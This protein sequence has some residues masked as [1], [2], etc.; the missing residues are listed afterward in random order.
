MN[1]FSKIF[2]SAKAEKQVNRSNFRSRSLNIEPLE[3][4]ALLS[5]TPL[6]P[7]SPV[8]FICPPYEPL[9]VW[10]AEADV[11][12]AP[13][14]SLEETFLLHSN[15]DA[16]HVIYLDFNGHTT[17]GTE[18]NNSYNYSNPISTPAYSFE[19]DLS[20]FSNAEKERIQYIWQR[21]AED[22]APFNVDVTTEEPDISH[23]IKTSTTYD[24][25]GYWGIRVV[26]GGSSSWLRES[27]GGVAYL[28]SFNWNSN[29]PVF[30]FPNN[31]N[32]G[33]EK[34][35]AEAISHEVGHS[36]G[37][38]H[39]GQYGT[40]YYPG[41]N[42]WAPIMGVGYD[43]P[44]VQW[45]RGEYPGATNSEDDLAIITGELIN[46]S[47]SFYGGN[48]FS[49]REDDYGDTP[50]TAGFLEVNGVNFS[51]SGIIEQNTDV[52]Y[53]AFTLPQ[54]NYVQFSIKSGTRDANLNVLAKIYNSADSDTP[55]A[56]GDPL[57]SLDAF[58]STK[59]LAAGTY[60]LTIEG[61]SQPNVFT[62][63][64]SIGTYTI[65]GNFSPVDATGD[66][67]STIVTT[68]EDIVDPNDG[69]IS[70][71]EAIDYTVTHNVG[72]VVRFDASLKNGTILL[73]G[74][75][76]IKQD[77]TIDGGKNNITID[78]NQ[79]SRVM[80]IT[81]SK[82][83][84]TL[85]GLTITG[86]HTAA[87]GG[88]IYFSS[89]YGALI[90]SN[91]TILGNTAFSNNGTG[92][93]YG[94]GIYIAGS[95]GHSSIINTVISENTSSYS[96]GGI[97]FRDG[98]VLTIIDSTISKNTTHTYGGGIFNYAST[99]SP[100]NASAIVNIT[101]SVITENDAKLG[102]GITNFGL[103]TITNSSITE[104][105]ASFRDNGA[106]G[107]AIHNWMTLIIINSTIARNSVDISTNPDGSIACGG[108]NN[109][110]N[111]S[112]TLRNTIIAENTA[113]G[114]PSDIDWSSPVSTN[115]SG[116]QGYN[117]LTSFED[118]T[119]DFGTNYVYNSSKPLFVGKLEDGTYDYHLAVDSPAINAG[120]NA[121][122]PQEITT[123]IEGNTRI[124]G[125]VVDIGAYE[126]YERNTIIVTTESDTIADDGV[127]SLREAILWATPEN[128]IITFDQS[129]NGKTLVMTGGV[130]YIN[131]DIVI[132]GT[133][134][135]LF[136]IDGNG[137]QIFRIGGRTNAVISGLTLQN[138]SSSDGGAV[139]GAETSNITISE[140]TL[141]NNRA[142]RGGAI[143]T[144]GNLTLIDTDLI[145]NTANYGGGAIMNIPGYGD[146][147][148]DITGGHMIGNTASY[149]GG[150]I[151]SRGD[152][153]NI[154][155]NL[156]GVEISKNR[157]MHG[158][159]V[160]AG[161]ANVHLTVKECLITENTAQNH[162][163]GLDIWGPNGTLDI[164]NSVITGNTAARG[165]GI[166]AELGNNSTAV[167][168]NS[169]IAK[170]TSNEGSGIAFF[171]NEN[172]QLILNNTTVA[173]NTGSYGIFS[174]Y[175]MIVLKNSLVANQ[176]AADV[177]GQVDAA[178]SLIANGE[179][180]SFVQNDHNIIGTPEYPIDPLFANREAGFYLLLPNSPA[181]NTGNNA[182]I[183][184]G[185]TTDLNGNA[186]IVGNAV[187]I[188]AYESSDVP[189][190]ETPS[191]IVTTENDIVNPYDHEISL[192]EAIQYANATNFTVTF[193]AS[194]SGKTIKLSHGEIVLNKNLTINGS[195]G[196][197]IIDADQKSRVLI[198]R[199][200]ANVTLVGLTIT[201]GKAEEYQSQIESSP[202][203]GGIFNQ[204]TLTVIDSKIIENTAQVGGGG[205]F[206][207]NGILT[208]I[209]SLIA[210]N[211]ALLGSG[212]LNDVG[213]NKTTITNS[214]IT[215]NTATQGSGGGIYTTDILNINNTIITGNTA[216]TNLDIRGPAR[217]NQNLS[218]YI[219][220]IDSGNTNLV[221]DPSQQL[222][223]DAANGD[224]HLAESSQAV[225]SGSNTLITPG[226]TK[227]IEGNDRIQGG[228]VDIGAYES[229]YAIQ[230]IVVTTELDVVDL[231][232]GLTSL[233][234]AINEAIGGR[235]F[236]TF[237]ES[238]AG[239][240]IHLLDGEIVIDKT[241][242]IDAGHLNITI[243]ADQKSRVLVV[244]QNTNVTLVGLTITG[245]KAE[246]SQ[247]QIEGSPYGGGIFN[248]GTL[249][250]SSSK[251]IENTAR[252]GG[253]IFNANGILTVTNSLI[254]DNTAISDG[255]GLL[256]SGMSGKVTITNS[257]ITNNTTIQGHGGGICT[258]DLITINNT[259]V[260]ENTAIYDPGISGPVQGSN[261]LSSYLIQ[262]DNSENTNLVYDPSL[263]LFVDP[264]NGDYRLDVNSQ[265]INK[266][267]NDLANAAGLDA[268][269]LDLAEKLRI[270]D[271][272]ID[273][274]AYESQSVIVTE[275]ETPSVLVTTNIDK[276]NPYDGL[277]SIRE[278]I[279]YADDE[280]SVITF[281]R[282]LAGRT[283]RLLGEEIVIDKTVQIDAKNLN[284]TLD[285]NQKSRVLLIRPNANV[286]LI[287]LTF[288]NGNAHSSQYVSSFSGGGIFNQGMLTVIGSKIIENTAQDG[289]GF[290]NAS[291]V[292]TVINSLIADNTATY[293]GGGLF[294]AG[295][296]DKVIIT[297]STI[298][299]NTTIRGIGGGIYTASLLNINNTIIAG[300]IA[301]SPLEFDIDGVARGNNNLSSYTHWTYSDS[302]NT[303]LIYDPSLP[304]FVDAA[305]GDYHLAERSQAI[306]RGDDTF[307]VDSAGNSLV[308]DVTGEMLRK[309][310]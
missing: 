199:Q 190:I 128:N 53:F 194:M 182:L 58:V 264:A 50:E 131:E 140:S 147:V 45:S 159:A 234:E 239:K 295:L 272:T 11:S 228:V 12:A 204:G 117:N 171:S 299:N 306:D 292:L 240:T 284:I 303:N 229:P 218:S 212:L 267:N 146:A 219:Q 225:N 83:N 30:V 101:N 25:D 106:R 66:F 178:Y 191:T 177:Y 71:R 93:Y 88:G 231:S 300:N 233:R 8:L 33:S 136:T 81:G 150:A 259:I 127:T 85:D 38:L 269:S 75:I 76:V 112:L 64:A 209:N 21:V 309:L 162:G 223:I 37:L 296:S 210:D 125:G 188:G 3:D 72:N 261:N 87:D 270:Y 80:N 186:R 280:H 92:N 1:I 297:N 220:W 238:L 279:L 285:A 144:F 164:I 94:G 149:N 139:Y 288:M 108:I 215:N 44:V 138:G 9:N 90:V 68:L 257:T 176:F 104:N 82:L 151:Y 294:H 42:G 158:G 207:I 123:D 232:D 107:G 185:I 6:E 283:I 307:A 109:Y 161:A 18:W 217:G 242:Q 23:L 302:G 122:V 170:N 253:G 256:H 275:L 60:Y 5:A 197:I 133:G 305:N 148:I 74:E 198:V 48:G 143:F 222:F 247:S 152:G 246:S 99:S 193:A 184:A 180:I 16:H 142:I 36:L 245:G 274:G 124:Q 166:H 70:I 52:D 244:R 291:G 226:I 111:G 221:Y 169:L 273:I 155:V 137:G 115:Y 201:G 250:V 57:D 69:K 116:I 17:T 236:V 51:A 203:G 160:S 102:G 196:N 46:D 163:G 120:D 211:T 290:F 119:R 154:I 235:L 179:G 216:N 100:T 298:T 263:P 89:S 32:N 304:L 97:A 213:S 34:A 183:P 289:G 167:I 113:A 202:H 2:R 65:T 157:G 165:G 78:A 153:Q 268:D 95:Y 156:T 286:T 282:S 63:Y 189:D 260:L 91:S 84:V 49:Y 248:Q 175:A 214:T 192:R 276:I 118:W 301:I 134:R 135:D 15:P 24:A 174:P 22:F 26:I 278:A 55:I 19:G 4:R 258:T 39:D 103:M 40:E 96:G 73:D 121:W 205:L 54:S 79:R 141:S 20:S 208:V 29:T 262:G 168:T 255:G 62:D 241:I 271:G 86:G 251:I 181:V 98:G 59:N 200:N 252:V 132:E 27:A 266:G 110:S 237:D 308:Y 28:G 195:G 293:D 130:F 227:D 14:Y 105:T 187:D 243:D 265:A 173:D 145:N 249:I 35:V 224:Y 41:A 67:P 172:T 13:P 31:L 10:A 56:I 47:T 254:A 77:I 129:L 287:G 43:Q 281:D 7:Q 230:P 310:G 61:T 277:I 206:N 126:F 114:L